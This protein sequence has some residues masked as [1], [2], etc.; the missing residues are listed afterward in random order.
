G[1]HQLMKGRTTF[2]IA[3]RLSTIRKADQILVLE[4][5]QIIERGSHPELMALGGRYRSL[6]EKQYGVAVNRFI[7]AGE[8]DEDLART[9]RALRPQ[10]DVPVG[11][12]EEVLPDLG[13]RAALQ[14]VQR[15]P[16]WAVRLADELHVALAEEL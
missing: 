10:L 4:N 9:Y 15:V 2:V 5:G 8:D 13:I 14:P 1:L 12:V 16:L 3:H 6:Y 7:N 11:L